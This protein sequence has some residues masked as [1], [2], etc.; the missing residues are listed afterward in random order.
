MMGFRREP[1]PF[2][3]PR[4]KQQREQHLGREIHFRQRILDS[5]KGPV[6]IRSVAKQDFNLSPPSQGLKEA[7]GPTQCS[8]LLTGRALAEA[9]MNMVTSFDT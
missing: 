5:S 7:I 9:C 4:K 2:A 8:D 3:F 1:S 6:V